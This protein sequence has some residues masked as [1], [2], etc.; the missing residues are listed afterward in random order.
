MVDFLSAEE[1]LTHC[2]HMDKKDLSLCLHYSE[3]IGKVSFCNPPWQEA[4]CFLLR[5]ASQNTEFLK[6]H[7]DVSP[8]F[9]LF[10]VVS[11]KG[12]LAFKIRGTF[13]FQ[14][15]RSYWQ[16]NKASSADVLCLLQA[17]VEICSAYC[18]SNEHILLY[19]QYP[20][21]RKEFFKDMRPDVLKDKF[22]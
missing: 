2:A 19:S 12:N 21:Y 11:Q 17:I 4:V 18:K 1:R 20:G 10:G 13:F 22:I 14:W 16:K 9:T 8:A 6:V 7:V 5:E 15:E 3:A